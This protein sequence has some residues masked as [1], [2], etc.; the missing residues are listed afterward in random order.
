M[1]I[2]VQPKLNQRRIS[3]K[4][5]VP[6]PQTAYPK[7]KMGTSFSPAREASQTVITKANVGNKLRKRFWLNWLTVV[8][9]PPLEEYTI[10]SANG[11]V[12]GMV[13]VM[14]AK[15]LLCF[16]MTATRMITRTEIITGMT[17]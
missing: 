8:L 6:N 7:A 1:G 12:N 13:A 4:M 10:Q 14:A 2:L 9:S 17:S 16:S 11:M 5:V 3:N 15:T